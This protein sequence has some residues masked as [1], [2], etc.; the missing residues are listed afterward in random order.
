MQV[1]Q[2]LLVTGGPPTADRPTVGFA[3]PA[4][5]DRVSKAITLRVGDCRAVHDEIVRR[6]ATF[7]TE[8][9]DRGAEVRAFLRDPDGHLVELSEASG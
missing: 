1:T 3:P 4:D 5:A 6:G 9:H 8:P 7:L 2:I